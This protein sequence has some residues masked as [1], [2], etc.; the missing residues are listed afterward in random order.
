MDSAALL[1]ASRQADADLTTGNAN[2]RSRLRSPMAAWASRTVSALR[3]KL[4]TTTPLSDHLLRDLGKEPERSGV[5]G[6]QASFDALA[7]QGL[8]VDDVLRF[9]RP[10]V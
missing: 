2:F 8:S 4:S 6:P 10:S 5:A 3:T 7:Q 9:L 1:Q